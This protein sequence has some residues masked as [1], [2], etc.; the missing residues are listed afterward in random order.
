MMREH[1]FEAVCIAVA[2]FVL[3]AIPQLIIKERQYWDDRAILEPFE[4]HAGMH[5]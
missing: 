5:R 4:R 3:Y 2:L 1:W